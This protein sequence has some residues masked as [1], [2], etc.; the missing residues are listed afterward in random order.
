[1]SKSEQVNSLFGVHS[2]EDHTSL[3]PLLECLCGSEMFMVAAWF[4]P[5][6]REI[7]GYILDGKCLQCGAVVQLP[8]PMDQV[9]LDEHGEVRYI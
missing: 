7:G 6:T 5:D 3:G 1:M 9:E 2:N 4:D 8:T